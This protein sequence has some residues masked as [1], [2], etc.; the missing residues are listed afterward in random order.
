MICSVRLW[1]V[2]SL[3]GGV[4]LHTQAQTQPQVA[5]GLIIQLKPTP[6]EGTLATPTQVQARFQRLGRLAQAT[7]YTAQMPWRHLSEHLV[8]M[9]VPTRLSPAMQKK[10]IDRLMASGQVAW[11]EPNVKQP[12]AQSVSSP[13]DSFYVGG[14]LADD[15]QSQWWMKNPAGA[16]RA[17]VPGFAKA[18]ERSTGTGRPRGGGCGAGH[19][20]SGP[21]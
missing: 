16:E 13:D 2:A 12:L 17:G 3:L 20:V 21:R 7:G 5:S 6:A 11:V 15:A 9:R 14:L 10:L 4:W 19:G 1:V 18:W 8:S